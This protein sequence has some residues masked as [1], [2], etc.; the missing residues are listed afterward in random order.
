MLS[1][2]INIVK[3]EAYRII[4]DRNLISILLIAPIFYSFF[5]GTVYLNKAESDVPIAIID[6]DNSMLTRKMSRYID[7]HKMIK[8]KYNL[9]NFIEA[10]NLLIEDEIQG[11]VYFESG[12]EN[13]VK[14]KKGT[15][16]TLYL[17]NVR[18]MASNDLNKSINEIIAEINKDITIKYFAKNGN[19]IQQAAI[20]SEPISPDLRNLFNP[21]GSY[22]DFLIPGVLILILQQTLLI[23]LAE[24][25][26][27]ER[28]ENSLKELM[29]MAGNNIINA[30]SGKLVIYLVIYSVYSF[31]FFSIT[32]NILGVAMN[33]N[34]FALIISTLL[35][36][37]AVSFLTLFISTFFKRKILALQILTLTSYPVFLISGFSWPYNSMPFG[38]KVI[39]TFLP[40]TPYMNSFIRTARMGAGLE[41]ILI[42]ITHITLIAVIS[43]LLSVYR[44]RLLSKDH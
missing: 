41:H 22:G 39:A 8:V 6:Y 15:D 43:L 5:Y 16:V 3:R 31:F 30:V 14:L 18:F 29:T 11:I 4:T 17:N 33:I 38:I 26:A 25:F 19:N 7:S 44:L 40:S 21:T 37:I 13:N 35:F 12:F 20:S 10:E 24:S 27:K 34:L 9:N 36:L 2:I 23:G 1:N 28:E 32:L 42:E